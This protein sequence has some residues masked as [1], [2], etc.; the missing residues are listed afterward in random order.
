MVGK[1]VNCTHL[2]SV[3][4]EVLGEGR[5]VTIPAS[6]LL[7][8]DRVFRHSLFTEDDLAIDKVA[9]EVIDGWEAV[10]DNYR[11]IGETPWEAVLRLSEAI[12]KDKR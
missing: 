1:L 8:A 3:R 10:T 4:I 2:D 5:A 7:A 6:L 11:G 9:D 12:E